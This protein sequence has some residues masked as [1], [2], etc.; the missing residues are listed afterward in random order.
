MV[1]LNKIIKKVFWLLVYS[2]SYEILT[3]FK[4]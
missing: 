3:N 1:V 4:K 2:E